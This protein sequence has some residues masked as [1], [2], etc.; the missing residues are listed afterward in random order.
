[1]DHILKW[2]GISL[3]CVVLLVV[4]A[5]VVFYAASD[6]Q[7]RRTY[8]TPRLILAV[9]HD[10]A[11]V[12]AGRFIAITRGCSGCHNGS[13]QGQVFFDDP[14][15][16]R[17]VTPNITQVIQ[18]YSDSQLARALRYGVRPNGTSVVIMPSSMLYYLSDTDLADLIAY[19]R[20]VPTVTNSLPTTRIGILG[21]W[22]FLTGKIPFQA[23]LIQKLGPRINP[24]KPEAT[25][26]YGDYL[27]HST[28]TECHGWNLRG[29][30]LVGAPDLIVAKAYTQENFARLMNTGIGNGNRDLGLM[31]EVARQRFSHFNSVQ[32][33]AMYAYLQ[34]L[35]PAH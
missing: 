13:L 20:S 11:A 14:W 30:P 17:V 24:G 31:S 5:M 12:A 8:N 32:V 16:G 6:Y 1:M 3:G 33:D 25:A 26:A 18:H 15:I 19:L 34:T 21:R 23:A 7:F 4:L 2:L 35:T 28:C 9:P 10:P 27:V 29:D 22:M